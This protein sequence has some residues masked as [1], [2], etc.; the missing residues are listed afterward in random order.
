[1]T[2]DYSFLVNPLSGGGAAPG[3]VVPVARRLREAGAA[4]EVTYS[5]GP[6]A[7][8]DLVRAAVGR[9]EVVVSVG[10]DGMLSSVAGEVARL[11]GTLGIV[12]AGR[13]NDFARMLG[14]P[15]DPDEVARLLLE[16]PPRPVDLLAV[17]GPDG[18]DRVV[19]GSVYA[20]VDARA[21]RLVDRARWLPRRLQYPYA[22]VRSLATYRPAH[23]EVAVD[24][25][26]GTFRAATVVVA[27][28]GYY[29]S[30]MHIAPGASL[31]DGVLDVVVIEAAGRLDL[32]RSLP[33]VYDGGHVALPGVHVLRGRLVEVR[34]L[35]GPVPVGGDG[36]SLGELR[37]GPLTARVLPEALAVLA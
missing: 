33:T 6:R 21:S 32:I 19:A 5:P 10:G 26:V 36:E 25:T 17:R 11:G 14:L 37:A 15:D 31:D 3:A 28:S 23:L 20:G 24:G 13:G 2:R 4:V 29:G 30:G 35:A 8:L 16:A 18:A 9:G 1:M 22:A 27:N 34:S 12:P 7:T